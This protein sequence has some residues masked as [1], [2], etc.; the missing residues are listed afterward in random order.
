LEKILVSSYSYDRARYGDREAREALVARLRPRMAKMAAHYAR[1]TNE[2]ADDLLQEAWVGLLDA[3]TQIDISIGD[4]DQYLLKHARWRLLDAVKRWR[5]RRCELLEDEQ[6]AAIP[7]SMDWN[8]VQTDLSIRAFT[9]GLKPTQQAVLKS[10]LRG[11]TWREAGDELGCSS[12]NV[13]YH[14]KQIQRQYQEW[15]AAG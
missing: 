13:A 7:S 14:V 2:N 15:S 8:D 11:M 3:L 4:P 10:L 12:A 6:V 5:R 1:C 9:G